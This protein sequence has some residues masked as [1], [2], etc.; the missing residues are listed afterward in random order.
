MNRLTHLKK[1]PENP[2][3]SQA[4]STI[5]HTPTSSTLPRS[6]SAPELPST[7]TPKF[8]KLEVSHFAGDNVF[9]WLVQIEGYFMFHRI[10]TEQQLT[11]ASFYLIGEALVYYHHLRTLNCLSSWSTFA[12]ALERHFRA[13]S[14]ISYHA[15]LFKLQKNRLCEWISERV[16]GSLDSYTWSNGWNVPSLSF[17]RLMGGYQTSC[18][19]FPTRIPCWCSGHHACMA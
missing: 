11:I 16:W 18:H 10:A 3:P 7:N 5:H 6:S 2:S 9:S 8:P 15:Q 17:I 12:R 4:P 1:Q 14:F 13:W 19:S